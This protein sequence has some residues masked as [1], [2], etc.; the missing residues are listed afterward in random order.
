MRLAYYFPDEARDLLTRRLDGSDGFVQTVSFSSDSAIV[1][2]VLQILQRTTNPGVFADCLT[3][4]VARANPEM[5]LKRLAEAVAMR[6]SDANPLYGAAPAALLAAR[7]YFPD[8]ARPLFETH[9]S[10][11]SLEARRAVIDALSDSGAALPWAVDVLAPLLS[12]VTETGATV[13]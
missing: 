2:R 6:P 11:A 5:V 9:L 8:R 13:G 4:A 1:T 10:Q 3:S 7:R 12:D